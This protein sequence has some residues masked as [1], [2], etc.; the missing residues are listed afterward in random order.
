VESPDGHYL[1]IADFS[2][3]VTVATVASVIASGIESTAHRSDA[4]AER[5]MPELLQYALA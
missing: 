1:Y 4:L 2:G 3:M 5:T